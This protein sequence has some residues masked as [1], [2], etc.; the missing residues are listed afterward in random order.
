MVR[1]PDL[2]AEQEMVQLKERHSE[3][4]RRLAELER[5]I[6]LTPEEQLERAGLKKEKLRSKDR[7]AVLAQQLKAA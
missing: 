3:I 1:T 7:L 4:E 5:H 6:S 2:G